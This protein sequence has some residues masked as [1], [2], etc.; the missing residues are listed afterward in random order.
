MKLGRMRTT[1]DLPDAVLEKARALAASRSMSLKRLMAEA[2]EEHLRRCGD[3]PAVRGREPP[4]MAGFGELADLADEN[5]R[6]LTLIEEE[7]ESVDPDD[8]E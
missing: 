1:V 7:F 2:L 3:T 6:I 5:R 4:W 8:T